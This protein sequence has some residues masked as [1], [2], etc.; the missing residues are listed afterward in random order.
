MLL[1]QRLG[2]VLE[3]AFQRGQRQRL[4]QRFR[5][6]EIAV[7]QARQRSP[8]RPAHARECRRER[9]QRRM[10]AVEVAAVER[11]QRMSHQPRPRRLVV[12]GRV[13]T[14]TV[15]FGQQLG[16]RRGRVAVLAVARALADVRQ[17]QPLARGHHGFQEQVAVVAGHVAVAEAAQAR[18]QVDAAI[19]WPA[20]KRAFV[21]PQHADH[22]ERD[23]A[24][25]HHAAE[26]DAAHQEALALR[27][28]GQ[29]VLQQLT[30]HRHAQRGV[31]A[32]ARRF[33]GELGD[34]AM[35]HRQ[36]G[37]GVGIGAVDAQQRVHALAQHR[38]PPACRLFDR[39]QVAPR[40]QLAQQP[41]QTAQRRRGRAFD[42]GQW[43]QCGAIGQ[44]DRLRIDPARHVGHQVAGQ[45]P[46]HRPGEAVLGARRQRQCLLV[47]SVQRPGHAAVAQ[48]FDQDIGIARIQSQGGAHLRHAQQVHHLGRGD[49][50]CAQPQQGVE[51]GKQRMT[52]GDGHVGEVVG[53]QPLARGARLT[54]HRRDQRQVGLDVGRHHRDIAG[55]H[56]RF[57]DGIQQ[58]IAQH[59]ELALAGV[60]GVDA[61]AGIGRGIGGDRI[62]LQQLRLQ[63]ADAVLQ[64]RQSIGRRA[65]A[66]VLPMADV[67]A[68]LIVHQ[69]GE[70]VLAQ[71]SPARQQRVALLA[72]VER[73]GIV[74]ARLFVIAEGL[75]TGRIGLAPA[76][77][78]RRPVQAAPVLAAGIGHVQEYRRTARI[79]PQHRQF[80]R[81]QVRQTH[82]VQR[83]ARRGIRL[84]CRDQRIDQA[85]AML[86]QRCDDRLPERRE[87]GRFQCPQRRIAMLGGGEGVLARLPGLQPV[88]A[89]HQVLREH[90]RQ[91]VGQL[92]AAQS[93]LIG[94]G[95]S[96]QV[97]QHAWVGDA[98][99]GRI[100]QH[101]VQGPA[102]MPTAVIRQGHRACVQ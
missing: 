11:L 43:Q 10:R 41:V 90:P 45:Q 27:R 78:P 6:G 17:V 58:R 31:L 84:Q 94:A 67:L 44:R 28:G 32:V 50:R 81:R 68:Q 79:G 93:A 37:A 53:Q 38:R 22:G 97:G 92:E 19:G 14:G 29:R 91:P 54:E 30:H 102:Q 34:R 20:R 89:I 75:P 63:A 95:R 64:A 83:R 69:G 100:A 98:M 86:T 88:A 80:R 12:I 62:L 9:K 56:P 33:R 77:L 55:T 70:E 71:A 59:F 4:R 36:R 60:A 13:A 76:A 74:E 72:P 5:R 21:Q 61:Q 87:A 3:E 42:A 35:H 18:H 101:R 25:R 66:V 2:R 1:Q 40:L 7:A 39:G 26:G 8:A 48:P 85:A 24:L 49:A 15:E 23:R 57:I 82:H 51:H 16:Q 46:V 73:I 96:V 47:R 99:R 52:A 65:G